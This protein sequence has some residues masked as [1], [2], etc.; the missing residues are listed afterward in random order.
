MVQNLSLAPRDAFALVPAT[1]KGSEWDSCRWEGEMKVKIPRFF[2]SRLLKS[3]NIPGMVIPSIVIPSVARDLLFLFSLSLA[4]SLALSVSAGAQQAKTSD[5]ASL[6]G[7]STAREGS[8]VGTVVKYD[9]ASSTPPLG[10]HVLVQTASGQVDVNLGNAKL[11]EANHLQ[12]NA[13]DSVRIV[14]EP[15]ALGNATY[16]AARIIQ[17]GSQAVAVRNTK[18]W[19]LTPASTLTEAQREA[20]RGVR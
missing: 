12:L 7:Y 4:G 6:Q 1:R 8:L 17:K 2:V 16:F 10:A 15:L 18:G 9:P 20:L 3:R 5:L 13:G 14:G 19:P 11:L